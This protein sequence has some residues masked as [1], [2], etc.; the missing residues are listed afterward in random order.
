VLAFVFGV[1][2]RAGG[3]APPVTVPETALF[4]EN[5]IKQARAT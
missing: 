2:Q 1:N 5:G 4:D 3:S